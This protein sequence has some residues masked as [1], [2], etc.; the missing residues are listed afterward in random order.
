MTAYAGSSIAMFVAATSAQTHPYTPLPLGWLVAWWI[1]SRRKKDEIGGWLL[2]YYW[3]L[4]A[5][6]V[7]SMFLFFGVSIDSYTAENLPPRTYVLFLISTVPTLV[8]T[9][10]QAAVSTFL[11]KIRSWDLVVLL[12]WVLAANMVA[13]LASTLIDVKVFPDNLP[14]DFMT[15]VPSIVW[16]AYFFRS[17][18]VQHVFRTHDW[19]PA[20]TILSI[21]GGINP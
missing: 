18:R 14:F 17:T 3:Q 5:G 10:A 6:L 9:L 19:N 20:P 15:L 2:Y 1:C 13:A 11:L 12:R 21:A 8:L 7:V 16:L 4:Y